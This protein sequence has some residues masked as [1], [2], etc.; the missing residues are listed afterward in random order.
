MS[1]GCNSAFDGEDQEQFEENF[2]NVKGRKLFR[3]GKG[4]DGE[5]DDFDQFNNFVDDAY[6]DFVDDGEDDNFD[7]FLTK[8]MRAR[9]KLKKSLEE[10]GM[11]GSEAKQKALEQIPRDKLKTILANMK[12]GKDA[13][14]SGLTTEQQQ[15]VQ[16]SGT[17]Q[18]LDALNNA[19][20]TGIQT[21]QQGTINQAE[22]QMGLDDG[23]ETEEAGFFKKNGLILGGVAV[24]CVVGFVLWKKGVFG[25]KGK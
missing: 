10:Q 7:N 13:D 19:V 3:R 8:K 9:R 17:N 18:V 6:T 21:A 20:S 1:C 12:K 4:F 5:E 23:G 22:N 11:S 15:A 24:A 14:T 2:D 25:K 16:S